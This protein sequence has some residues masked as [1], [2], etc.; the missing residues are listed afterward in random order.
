MVADAIFSFPPRLILVPKRRV[1]QALRRGFADSL[2]SRPAVLL[3]S[4]LA[5][6]TIGGSS[7]MPES[8][9]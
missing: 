4:G 6:S 1:C 5:S 9:S 3:H 2:S 8:G 7:A